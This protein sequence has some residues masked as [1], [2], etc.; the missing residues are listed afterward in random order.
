MVA[1]FKFYDEINE[2]VH[3]FVREKASYHGM[4]S[5][6]LSEEDIEKLSSGK[7]LVWPI[8]EYTMVISTKTVEYGKYKFFQS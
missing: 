3:Q 1:T 4:F 5:L 8:G 6:V 2:E 7:Y